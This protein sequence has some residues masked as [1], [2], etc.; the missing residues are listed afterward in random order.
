M[1]SILDELIDFFEQDDWLFDI[2]DDP[3]GI[4]TTF[5]RKSD[6]WSCEAYVREERGQ[7]V[8]YSIFPVHVPAE[9]L[10]SVAE[11]ITRANF[12]MI[13]GNFELNY[14]DGQIRYKTSIDVK[15]DRISYPLIRQ[16]VYANC[17]TM[18]NYLS[19]LMAVIYTDMPPAEAIAR[20]E[21]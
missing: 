9:K 15:G 17:S 10:D 1:S 20:I 14:E 6:R 7:C 13:I 8:F 2:I 16:M 11:F 5:F 19:G 3:P 18:G 12:G 21:A 4:R